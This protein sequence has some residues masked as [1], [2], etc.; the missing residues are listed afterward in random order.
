MSSFH[1]SNDRHKTPDRDHGDITG[2]E[3]R[4]AIALG[5]TQ[6]AAR[7]VGSGIVTLILLSLRHIL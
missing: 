2:G 6:G 3:V 4:K 1:V 5:A 7:R